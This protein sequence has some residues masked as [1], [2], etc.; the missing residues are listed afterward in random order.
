MSGLDYLAQSDPAQYFLANSV[1][2]LLASAMDFQQF[3]DLVG[4]NLS[5]AGA[6]SLNKFVGKLILESEN[7]RKAAAFLNRSVEIYRK[8]RKEVDPTNFLLEM[9]MLSEAEILLAQCY[10]RNC[11][12]YQDAEIL[13]APHFE[14]D[15]ASPTS[16]VFK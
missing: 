4:G 3:L 9:D 12:R 13:L 2:Y 8:L 16:Q 11:E 5:H 1:N 14:V 7:P 15:S 6:A 10:I